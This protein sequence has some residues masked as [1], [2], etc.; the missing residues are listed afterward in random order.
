MKRIRIVHSLLLI[1]LLGASTHA[2]AQSPTITALERKNWGAALSA[3]SAHAALNSFVRWHY[4]KHD[5]SGARFD[6]IVRFIHQHRDWPDLNVLRLRA[7][8][9]A[10][11]QRPA[12]DAVISFFSEYPPIS[13]YGLMTQA[14]IQGGDV[15]ALVRRGW[16]QGD[17][18]KAHEA[19]ILESYNDILDHG[20]HKRRIERLL[21]QDMTNPAERLLSFVSADE[22]NLYRARIA[23]I[24]MDQN[25]DGK[26]DMVP[27]SLKNDNGLLYDRLRWRYKKGMESGALE[28]L[29]QIDASSPYAGKAWKYRAIFARDYIERRRFRDAE[30]LLLQHGTREG[31]DKADALFMLGW[32][33]LEYLNK[34]S[35]ALPH[36]EMLY[37]SVQ[38]PVSKARGAYWAARA[39]EAM[40]QDS[41]ARSWYEKASINLTTFYGQ[42]AYA[43]LFPNQPLRLPSEPVVSASEKSHFAK[44]PMAEAIKFLVQN[45]HEDY[46]A[47]LF[48]HL[49]NT[50]ATPREAKLVAELAREMNLTFYGVRASKY[51]MRNNIMLFSAGWPTTRINHQALEP[52]LPH[53]IARQESEFNKEA[54]SSANARGLMQLLPGTAQMV[55]RKLDMPYSLSKL[56][57]PTYNAT[58]GSKYLGDLVSGFDGSY[59]LAIAGYNAGPG[60]SRE[61]TS[62][63]G[64]PG[65]SL[66]ETIN[67]IEMIPFYETRNYVQRVLENVQVYRALM[68][69]DAPLAIEKDLLR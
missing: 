10:F 60:R 13:G 49:G 53:A 18:E 2:Q 34:A 38:Y 35:A 42:L 24:R 21:L 47:P 23:L 30:S 40:G 55:A 36:F 45:K 6:E 26:L 65:A 54:V 14:R 56:N 50:A 17:F 11:A 62:R 67:W 20:D 51:A 61:W 31:A 3:S 33:Q 48:A 58:L 43:K 68:Q 16:E 32:V 66:H 39:A 29:R 7:E 37:Q 25:V 57:D 63:F 9:A 15:S 69:P 22:A 41:L 64:R 27:A 19:H 44:Q 52:A 8:K 28:L 59:I 12:A 1:G 5:S 46:A 4:Y